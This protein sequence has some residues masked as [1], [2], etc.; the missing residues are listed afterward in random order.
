MNPLKGSYEVLN[1]ETRKERANEDPSFELMITASVKKGVSGETGP[2]RRSEYRTADKGPVA[3]DIVGGL[4]TM[5]DYAALFDVPEPS[6]LEL[7][8]REPDWWKKAGCDL[9]VG[10]MGYRTITTVAGETLIAEIYPKW[11]RKE[12][13][14][15]RRAKKNITPDRMKRYNSARAKLKLELLMDNN[16]TKD[17]LSLTLTYT[18]APTEP[19]ARKDIKNYLARI[20]RLR[21]KEGL[22]ELKYIYAIE[23]ERDGRVK[24]LHCH[25]VMSGGIDRT[26]A[27]ELW[28]KGSR[29]RGYAN[30]DKLQPDKEGLRKL[31]FYIYDQN[32][33][34]ETTKGKRHYS[35]SKNLK[36]PKVR[37]SVS[38]VSN[39]KVRKMARDFNA[40]AP[41]IME[42]VYPGYMFVRGLKYQ[43]NDTGSMSESCVRFSDYTDGVY[44]RVMMRR[45]TG[46]IKP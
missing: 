22:P 5:W 24:Q 21:E 37:N 17:D 18:T 31:A 34:K 15:L 44:I 27:E 16:F 41:E 9:R 19:D 26:T 3:P 23:N 13:G 33:G 11:G 38:R 32:R 35:C 7:A 36:E 28:Q 43:E 30:C 2:R 39:A 40:L 1:N 10:Q 6:A 20:R 12:R 42:K 4:L 14:N 45:I 29:A 25:I 8:M 46:G